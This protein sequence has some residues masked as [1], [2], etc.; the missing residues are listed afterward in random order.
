MNAAEKKTKAIIKDGSTL[1][2]SSRTDRQTQGTTCHN[3]Q[4]VS[5]MTKWVD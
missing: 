2:Q 4:W 1:M 3:T 5:Q